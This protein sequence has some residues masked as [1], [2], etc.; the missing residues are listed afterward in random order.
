MRF[1][2]KIH[3]V[4]GN[5]TFVLVLL[6][7]HE[8]WKIILITG[9]KQKLNFLNTETELQQ[10]SN[11]DNN[12]QIIDIDC[13]ETI[14]VAVTNDNAI[15]SIPTLVHQLPKHQKIKKIACGN[16]HCVLLTSNGDIFCWGMGT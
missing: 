9:E 5:N 10:T 14:S 2:S 4:C 1:S 7:T 11:E 12:R 16:E 6:D 3:K 15:F 8:L 13:G